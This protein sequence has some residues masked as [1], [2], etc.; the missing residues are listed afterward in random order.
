MQ[1]DKS[2]RD[3]INLSFTDPFLHRCVTL[4]ELPW[5]TREEALVQTVILLAAERARLQRMVIRA[6]DT[7]RT[8]EAK[9]HILNEV[10]S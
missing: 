4:S 2:W 10:P 1:R 8:L 3:L 5:S 6:I 9:E 7:A